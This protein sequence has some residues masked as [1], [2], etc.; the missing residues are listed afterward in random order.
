MNKLK[1]FIH[2]ISDIIMALVVIF[3]ILFV[4]YKNI[5]VF[6]S[7]I[8]DQKLSVNIKEMV[9]D[10]ISNTS[11]NVNIDSKKTENLEEKNNINTTTSQNAKSADE[12]VTYQNKETNTSQTEKSIEQ[13]SIPQNINTED[14]TSDTQ[15][16]Q[17][18]PNDENKE[19]SKNEITKAVQNN[20][21][22]TVTIV[23]PANST[24][25]QI[26][27]I[28]Y[29]NKLI[30]SKDEINIYLK[31]NNLETKLK[32]GTF[33]INSKMSVEEIVDTISL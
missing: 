21:N 6:F 18:N 11:I 3:I 23:I 16:L 30:T 28:L 27:D 12:S 15:N 32:S 13:T 26:V 19:N 22:F 33:T 20:N 4:F 8:F 5:S 7:D 17:V 31:E 24:S 1:D 29:D 25:T 9:S 10:D 2:Y 14:K